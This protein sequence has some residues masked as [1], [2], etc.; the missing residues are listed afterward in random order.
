MWLVDQ[1][2]RG[3]WRSHRYHL[4]GPTNLRTVSPEFGIDAKREELSIL[5]VVPTPM[6]SGLGAWGRHAINP[7]DCARPLAP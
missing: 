6:A 7:P 4:G 1:S 2:H 5:T 3:D